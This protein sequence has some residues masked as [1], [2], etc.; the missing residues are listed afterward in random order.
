MQAGMEVELPYY[1]REREGSSFAFSG[2]A[3]A[4]GSPQAATALPAVHAHWPA[5]S[6]VVRYVAREQKLQQ[7]RDRAQREGEDSRAPAKSTST[8][9]RT[10]RH[11][12]HQQP[13]PLEYLQ[14]PSSHLQRRRHSSLPRTLSFLV[15]DSGADSTY[16]SNQQSSDAP[17]DSNAALSESTN[18]VPPYESAADAVYFY[19]E[20]SCTYS[21]EGEGPSASF[22]SLA[23]EPTQLT[24]ASS[25]SA[26]QNSF[27]SSS[28]VLM[29][30]E[31]GSGTDPRGAQARR[32]RFTIM[33]HEPSSL[34]WSPSL[35]REPTGADLAPLLHTSR[36]V[37]GI[38]T[39]MGASNGTGFG[40]EHNGALGGHG[41]HAAHQNQ[42]QNQN[43]QAD[44]QNNS[45][46]AVYAFAS[47]ASKTSGA[48]QHAGQSGLRGS[49]YRPP[50]PGRPL[51][52]ARTTPRATNL[53]ALTNSVR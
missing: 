47:P 12:A 46:E 15:E 37:T 49:L 34:G 27:A 33:E 52:R 17:Q 20:L 1:L 44:H 30:D 36:I 38:G 48:A 25:D 16:T 42:N 2:S 28:G 43:H 6:S 3:S 14:Y 24:V 8:D 53:P 10:A 5:S 50:T 21:L 4:S 51:Q 41:H 19:P 39:G 11:P 40:T 32:V 29:S 13:D 9:A 23:R 45:G 35:E 26:H 31:G 22:D 18:P 7:L